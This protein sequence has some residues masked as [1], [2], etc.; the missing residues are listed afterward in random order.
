MTVLDPILPKDIDPNLRLIVN[1]LFIFH[2]CAFLCYVILLTRSYIKGKN[3]PLDYF[4]DDSD[5]TSKQKAQPKANKK[6]QHKRD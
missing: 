3:E 5:D 4:S 2:I 1:G 6:L